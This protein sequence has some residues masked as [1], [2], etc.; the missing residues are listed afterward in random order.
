MMILV[1]FIMLFGM[2]SDRVADLFGQLA[3]DD[4]D[5]LNDNYY[6]GGQPKREDY[7]RL[8]ALGIRSV[9]DLRQGGP[10]DEQT[11][12]ENA[13][14]KFYSIPMTTIISAIGTYHSQ[15]FTSCK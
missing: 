8:A 9:V 15:V 2:S 5:K 3:V 12:V 7:A 14:M 6:R 13:G 11:L 10:D 4:F 1:I